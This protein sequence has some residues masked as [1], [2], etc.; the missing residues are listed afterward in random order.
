[1]L[2]HVLKITFHV[3][4]MSNVQLLATWMICCHFW[5][6]SCLAYVHGLPISDTAE[7]LGFH[8]NANIPFGQ[9]EAFA[10]LKALACLQPRVSRSSAEGK[11]F[12]EV[13]LWSDF[14]F[15]FRH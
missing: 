10:L 4:T 14:Y 9:N 15:F 3:Q 12:E 6:Q 2:A 13:L 8:D 1:M 11:P 5:P 7:I